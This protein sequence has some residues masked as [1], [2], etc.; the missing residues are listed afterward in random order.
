M[1][2]KKKKGA[3]EAGWATAHFLSLSHDTASCIVTQAH[4]G[5]HGQARHGQQCI[6]TRPRHGRNTASKGPRHGRLAR[7]ASGSASAH[8]LAA[9]VCHDTYGCIVTGRACLVSRHSAPGAAIWR[10]NALRHSAEAM[11]HAGSAHDRD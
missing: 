9:G 8:S 1:K 7:G 5:V 11:Q 10:S 4:R 3:Q 2:K 6:T